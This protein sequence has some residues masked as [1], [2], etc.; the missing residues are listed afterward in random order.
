MATASD[1]PVGSI[2]R[3]G[4]TVGPDG[5]LYVGDVLGVL[6]ALDASGEVRWTFRALGEI[7]GR[8]AVSDSLVYIGSADLRLYALSTAPRPE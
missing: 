4:M 1:E 3:G 8:P 5:T 6:H 2:N 7:R